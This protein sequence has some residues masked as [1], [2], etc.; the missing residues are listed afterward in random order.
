MYVH[1]YFVCPFSYCA[2]GDILYVRG[3]WSWDC[4]ATS[5]S[6]CT[7]TDSNDSFLRTLHCNV[8]SGVC[9]ATYTNHAIKSS[10]AFPGGS[11]AMLTENAPPKHEAVAR[12]AA[13]GEVTGDL[14]RTGISRWVSSSMH[15][16]A[17]SSVRAAAANYAIRIAASQSACSLHAPRRHSFMYYSHCYSPQSCRA[18]CFVTSS[19][20]RWPHTHVR[21]S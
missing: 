2:V 21:R 12:A 5:V 17:S 14:K 15:L 9:N 20:M 11:V 6:I 10:A 8:S 19:A 4:N 13:R 18:S 1:S 7:K 16:P 3:A